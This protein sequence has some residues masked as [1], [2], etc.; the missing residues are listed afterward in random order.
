MES[1]QRAKVIYTLI[2]TVVVTV[3]Q[4]FESGLSMFVG[5]LNKMKIVD[6]VNNWVCL[7]TWRIIGKYFTSKSI[8]EIELYFALTV[9]IDDMH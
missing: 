9:E 3:K 1:M 5:L 8:A 2:H 7:L 6:I 4:Y